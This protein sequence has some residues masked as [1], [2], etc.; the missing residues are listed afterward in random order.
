MGQGGRALGA[1]KQAAESGA[2]LSTLTPRIQ[3]LVQLGEDLP[4]LLP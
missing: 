2:D 4:A 3:T 1:L